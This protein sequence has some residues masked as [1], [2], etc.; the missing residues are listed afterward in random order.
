LVGSRAQVSLYIVFIFMALI[1]VLV[2]GVI[3]PLGARFSAEV[4]T[5]GSNLLNDTRYNP[6]AKI[7][8]PTIRASL[9]NTFD[10]AIAASE[11]NIE[12]STGVFQ[13]GWVLILVLIGV[14]LFLVTRSLI[15]FSRQGPG[16]I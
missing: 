3:A 9:E 7:V 4:F 6:V 13:Y 5:A 11:T 8:D 10:G 1:I 12:V 15:A 14:V 16:V 2:A